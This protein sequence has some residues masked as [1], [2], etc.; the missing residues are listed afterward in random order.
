MFLLGDDTEGPSGLFLDEEHGARQ[1]AF[2]ARLAGSGLTTATV[3]TPD[4][5]YAALFQALT[6]LPRAESARSPAGRVWNVPARHADF[7]GRDELLA[8]LRT[9]LQTDGATVMQALHGMPSGSG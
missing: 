1:Q 9:A 7:T 4:G 8:E 5:L 2:R 3:T 6:E